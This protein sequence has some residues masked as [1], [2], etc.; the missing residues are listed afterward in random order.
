[1]W[2]TIAPWEVENTD[3][4]QCAG[5]VLRMPVESANRRLQ[6]VNVRN[7]VVDSLDFYPCSLPPPPSLPV[8]GAV[9]RVQYLWSLRVNSQLSSTLSFS[10]LLRCYHSSLFSTYSAY[11]PPLKDPST[12]PSSLSSTTLAWTRS[13]NS[14]HV[15][16][17]YV[18]ILGIPTL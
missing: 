9:D 11:C 14:I 7:R 3:P 15:E 5:S 8:D 13:I 1:M 6:P 16:K 2:H 4:A 10:G 12:L 17:Y 18:M